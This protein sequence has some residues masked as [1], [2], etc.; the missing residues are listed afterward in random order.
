MSANNDWQLVLLKQ[1]YK[2]G[3]DNLAEVATTDYWNTEFIIKLLVAKGFPGGC[4]SQFKMN[5]A[6]CEL[7]NR[8]MCTGQHPNKLLNRIY[9]TSPTEY[10]S[11][12]HVG[13]NNLWQ[14]IT[15]TWFL[16]RSA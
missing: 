3:K 5:W 15:A 6:L 13:Q 8:L 9:R 14:K 1:I 4:S 2:K 11:Q 10:R 12:Y 7:H 16:S